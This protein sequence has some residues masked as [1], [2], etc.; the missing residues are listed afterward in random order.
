MFQMD[1]CGVETSL[2]RGIKNTQKFIRIILPFVLALAKSWVNRLM[3][4]LIF[5]TLMHR[6]KKVRS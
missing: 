1:M 3:K 4:K 2:I 5:S 6:T